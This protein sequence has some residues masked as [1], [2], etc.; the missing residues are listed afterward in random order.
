MHKQTDAHTHRRAHTHTQTCTHTQTHRHTHIHNLKVIPV[1]SWFANVQRQLASCSVSPWYYQGNMEEACEFH[2]IGNPQGR[3]RMLI[4]GKPMSL[5]T[6]RSPGHS[7]HGLKP[8]HL[9][10]TCTINLLSAAPYAPP[11]RKKLKCLLSTPRDN[12]IVK[13]WRLVNE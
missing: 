3:L 12:L 10:F 13:P 5:I 8:S 7:G 11:P 6:P 4:L 9:V 1:H 2:C